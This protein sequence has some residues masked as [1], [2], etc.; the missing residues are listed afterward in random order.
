LHPVPFAVLS[1]S[2]PGGVEVIAIRGELDL[3]TAPELEQELDRVTGTENGSVV[4]DL[5][6]CEFI[7]STGVALLVRAWQSM[8][9]GG[10]P[11]GRLVLCSPSKQVRRLFDITGLTSEIDLLESRDDAVAALAA[12]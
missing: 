1:E 11:A 5:S 2:R 12:G 6:G 10:P 9:N 7:D 4:V 3:N 8:G